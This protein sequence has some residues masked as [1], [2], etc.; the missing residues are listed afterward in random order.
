M[1]FNNQLT[2]S[3]PS[4]TRNGGRL[5]MSKSARVYENGDIAMRTNCIVNEE[6][7]SS[8]V[9]YPPGEYHARIVAV[10]LYWGQ[11]GEWYLVVR[12]EVI[13]VGPAFGKTVSYSI[14]CGRRNAKRTDYHLLKLGLVSN[15]LS[16]WWNRDFGKEV[17]SIVVVPVRSGQ[18]GET[19]V[20]Y[21][22][23]QSDVAYRDEEYL[24]AAI[25]MDLADIV[26]NR[27][28]CLRGGRASW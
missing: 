15:D 16:T 11:P 22:Q 10:T 13:D 4:E 23:H 9:S 3:P 26:R 14:P 1:Q 21:F 7:V 8:V 24:E 18:R 27:V 17:W 2:N 25:E 5:K 6:C 12:F 19:E 28:R 20:R